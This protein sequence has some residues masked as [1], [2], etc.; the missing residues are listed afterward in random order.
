M[1]I[2]KKCF[3]R[4]EPYTESYFDYWGWFDAVEDFDDP[5]G[6]YCEVCGKE[7]ED[8]ESVVLIGLDI[9]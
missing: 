6:R 4:N 3:N 2:C 7:F 9:G 8:G 1:I 5:H